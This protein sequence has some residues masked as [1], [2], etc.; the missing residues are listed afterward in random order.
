MPHLYCTAG[1][2]SVCMYMNVHTSKSD[3]QLLLQHWQ[4]SLGT[5]S[6]SIP[7]IFSCNEQ[8][9][10]L[11]GSPKKEACRSYISCF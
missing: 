11:N 10:M 4:H 3:I 6:F 9:N 1:D 7:V 8:I 2:T 5:T